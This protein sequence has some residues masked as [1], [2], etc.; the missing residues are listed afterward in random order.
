VSFPIDRQNERTLAADFAGD[1]VTCDID[2]TYLATRFSS[3]KGLMRIPFEFGVDK[4]DIA[5]MVVLLKELRRGPEVRSRHTPLYFVSASPASLRGVI[6]RK[7]LLD[8]L[9]Y[10]G[11][12]FK[13]WGRCLRSRRFHRLREQLGYK[14]TALLTGRSE[15]PRAASELLFGDDLESDA[16]AFC[17][18]ADLVSGRI[19]AGAA[20][21]LLESLG[22]AADDAAHAAGLAMKVVGGRGVR[23]SYIRLERHTPEHFLEF[24]PHLRACRG[25][26]QLACG[27]LDDGAIGK[28]AVVRVASDL[29]ERGE[30]SGTIQ[31]RLVDAVTRGIIAPEL[32]EGLFEALAGASLVVPA[33][34]HLP[35]EAAAEWIAQ[36]AGALPER[37]LAGLSPA[38]A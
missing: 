36:R 2:R 35:A 23:R 13:D 21:P 11:T 38:R 5:G 33:G 15:M 17:T 6:E 3:L 1:V 37:Y 8:G 4:K 24:S 22:V 27:L 14:V 32:A 10:D 26:F 34:A 31:E 25:A 18:Y 28:D 29:V 16:L 19:S 20:P 7:M 30:S 9:E 12:T